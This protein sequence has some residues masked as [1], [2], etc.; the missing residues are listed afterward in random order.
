MKKQLILLTIVMLTGPIA[1]AAVPDSDAPKSIVAPQV[2]IKA[3]AFSLKNVRLL[4]GPF[5]RAMDLDAQYLLDLEPDRLLSRFR[6][7]AG[8]EPKGKIYGG[9]ESRGV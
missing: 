8:L 6:E 2:P 4:D 7:F 3:H 5:K 9:W 1:R